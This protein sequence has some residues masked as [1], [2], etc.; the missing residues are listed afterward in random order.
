MQSPGLVTN[1]L[2]KIAW[3]RPV[4]SSAKTCL[5]HPHQPLPPLT[6]STPQQQQNKIMHDK[7]KNFNQLLKIIGGEKNMEI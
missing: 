7:D 3:S 2:I 5:L 1:L 4:T 6:P